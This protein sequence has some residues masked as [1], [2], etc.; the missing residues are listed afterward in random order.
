MVII[1]TSW[2]FIPVFFGRSFQ[3]AVPASIVLA[4]GIIFTSQRLVFSGYFKAINQMQHPVRAAWAG[5][6]ITVL[7]DIILIPPLGIIGAAWAT[8]LAY[9][10]SSFY[11]VMMARRKLGFH[12]SAILFL[13][14][15]DIK[16][17]LS[18][19]QKGPHVSSE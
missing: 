7:L 14:K 13:R 12:L 18:K 19:N 17:L 9:G 5:V 16:W 10:T 2:F 3:L 15:S 11:L 1:G 8:T 6:L 4:I